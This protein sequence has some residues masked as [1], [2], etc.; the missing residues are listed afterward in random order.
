[1]WTADTVRTLSPDTSDMR[2]PATDAGSAGG[3]RAPVGSAGRDPGHRSRTEPLTAPTLR[4]AEAACE[5]GPIGPTAPGPVPSDGQPVLDRVGASRASR[6]A[7]ARWT[8]QP[9]GPRADPRRNHTEFA[10]KPA[11]TRSGVTPS[12]WYPK[13]YPEQIK[14]S[15]PK[16]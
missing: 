9:R 1:M 14:G 6:R 8:S 2:A 13:R 12:K 5:L 7:T 15:G 4:A 16:P 3:R 11:V 10:T